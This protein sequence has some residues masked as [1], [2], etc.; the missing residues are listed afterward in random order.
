MSNLNCI[1]SGHEARYSIILGFRPVNS[2]YFLKSFSLNMGPRPETQKCMVLI[3]EFTS[4]FNEYLFIINYS[5]FLK[6]AIRI[7]M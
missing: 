3:N 2:V 5:I 6:I 1:L 7:L 4:K